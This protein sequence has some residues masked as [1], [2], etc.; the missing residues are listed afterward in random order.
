MT[1]ALNAALAYAAE[2]LKVL[3]IEPV[4]P[5]DDT[6]GKRPIAALCPRGVLN[7]S[8]DPATIQRWWNEHPGAGVGIA[9]PGDW[10]CLDVD[11]RN[12]GDASFEA[13]AKEHGAEA[14]PATRESTTGGGGAHIVYTIPLGARFPGKIAGRKGLDVKQIG[15]YV[16]AWPSPHWSGGTYGRLEGTPAPAPEWLASLERGAAAVDGDPS[17]ADRELTAAEMSSLDDLAV[18]LEPHFELGQR[19]PMAVAIGGLLRNAGLPPSAADYVIDQLPSTAPEKRLKDALGAWRAPVAA[20][21]SKLAELLP[22]D[23]LAQVEA[24]DLRPDWQRRAATRLE[25]RMAEQRAKEA[26][27]PQPGGVNSDPKVPPGEPPDPYAILGKRIDLAAEPAEFAYLF[28]GLPYAPGGKVN[29]L[30]GK[31]NAGKSPFAELMLLSHATG[32]ELGPFKPIR[33][34][35]WGLYSDAETGLLAHRRWRRLCNAYGVDPGVARVDFRD[36]EVMFSEKYCEVLEAYTREHGPDGLIVID[37]YGAML[38]ADIDNNSPEFA[39]WLRALGRLSRAYAVTIVVLIHGNKSSK[40]GELEGIGGNIQAPGAMQGV[41]TLERTGKG[42]ASPIQVWCSRAPEHDFHPF[43]VVW[44]EVVRPNSKLQSDDKAER[45]REYWGLRADIVQEAQVTPQTEIEE[46]KRTKIGFAIIECLKRTPHQNKTKVCKTTRGAGEKEIARIFDDLVEAGIL[47]EIKVAE[48]R[49][50]KG[51]AEA[52]LVY[53]VAPLTP[54]V[55]EA[56][57]KQ[58]L[59]Q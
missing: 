50:G 46:K 5:G 36:V 49:N 37:T 20:G 12:G 53:E 30:A 16:V 17:A 6:S 8:D 35:G 9:V 40:D 33:P 34:N 31:P 26:E 54:A 59:A 39:F 48:R 18:V 42:N 19:N 23:V 13:I 24:V 25:Q 1:S 45:E 2:G 58:G 44:S 51:E 32:R 22:S 7:A 10:V 15:G 47:L 52:V 55:V 28:E 38:A 11:P 43:Q 21:V 41:I 56:K 3:P 14:W 57:L 29:G 27:R 4:R